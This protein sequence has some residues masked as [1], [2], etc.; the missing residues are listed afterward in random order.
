MLFKYKIRLNFLRTIQSV[1]NSLDN[2]A[3]KL[4]NY[5]SMAPNEIYNEILSKF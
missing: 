5:K 2:D 4:N 1:K 3:K